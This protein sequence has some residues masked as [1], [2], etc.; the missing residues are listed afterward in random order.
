MAAE[1]ALST[2]NE[3]RLGRVGAALEEG[4]AGRLFKLAK[5]SVRA[6]L[7]LRLTRPRGG[8]RVHHL[9]SALYLAAG[10]AFR[11]AWVD[12]GRHSAR[13]DAAVAGQARARAEI[14]DPDSG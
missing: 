14:V 5:W 9:A 11:F 6:G 10:L 12:A 1:L 2:L 13:D 3:R 4:R 8:P 7:A